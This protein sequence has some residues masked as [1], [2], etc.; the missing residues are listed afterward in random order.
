L[1]RD[2]GGGQRT[3]CAPT[4]GAPERERERERERE[5]EK[6]RRKRSLLLFQDAITSFICSTLKR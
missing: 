1:Y 5:T 3:A 2:M 6:E 4:G